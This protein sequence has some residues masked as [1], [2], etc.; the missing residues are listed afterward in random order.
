MKAAEIGA[1]RE[2]TL[3]DNREAL[4]RSGARPARRASS[5]AGKLL[6]LGNGGSATDAMD[7]VA[8]FRAP[9]RRP[10]R[11]AID[12]T[13]DP[14][15]LTAIANDIGVEAIFSR[16]VIAYG[17]RG[18]A[19]LAL[20]TSG[21]SAN[22]IE[23][24]AEARR[25]GL[26]TIAMV[27]Y[28]GGRDRLGGARR[29]RRRHALGAHP[30]HPG[31]AGERLPRAARAGRAAPGRRAGM[32][33]RTPLRADAAAA[34]GGRRRARVR[35]EGTVQ[36]VGFRPYVYRL[37]RELGPRR[38]RAQRRPRRAA[39]GR[40]RRATAVERFLARLQPEAPPLAVVERVERR[41]SRRTGES[42]FAIRESP[43]GQ[44]IRRAGHARQRDLRGLPARAV[45]PRRPPLP[46]PVHQLHQLRAALHDRARRPLRPAVHDDGR[47]S[48]CAS[49]AR[50]ST[51]IRAT[52][53]FTRSRTPA[54]SAGRRSRCW[55]PTAT[56]IALG[57]AGTRCGGGRRHAPCAEG[58]S[59]P[60]RA[61]A[62]STSPAAP[63]TSA[64]WR[65][66]A[67]ASTARTSRS[68]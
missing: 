41:A 45:R 33:A 29:P 48:R 39:R 19:L 61:S 66:C 51:R 62:A 12:L 4:L 9:L 49:A 10:S 57:A 65:R 22:V 43:R 16:Q 20:S 47:L 31:G 37:A 35:V 36:G 11:P 28:D 25:A 17:R 53:A 6:A 50:P 30:A 8:D 64:R 2:Q 27:G 58:R 56:P 52:G 38:L 14:A 5:V 1:L 21:N 34:R 3:T 55:R 24:L 54:R 40:G 7:V 60:S 18:D 32:S 15:I 67:R 42:G 44:S 68:R 23:A 59:S 13:E 63:T 26:L 46:L